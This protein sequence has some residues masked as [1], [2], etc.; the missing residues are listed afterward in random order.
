MLVEIHRQHPVV[1]VLCMFAAVSGWH[2]PDAWAGELPLILNAA[3]VYPAP[4]AAPIDDAVVIVRDG[5]ILAAASRAEMPSVNGH[6]DAQC[7]GG[8]V[9]AGFQNSHV[10]FIE[11]KWNDAGRQPAETL[12]RNLSEMLTRYGFTTVVDTA[13]DVDNTVALRR[14]IESG[15][16]KGPRILTT[17]WPL[18]PPDGIPIYLRDMPPEFLK[19]LPQPPSAEQAIGNVRSNLSR[20]ADAIKLFVATPIADGSVKYMSPEIVE[21]A[22]R[23]THRRGR[24]VGPPDGHFRDSRGAR[25]GRGRSRAHDARQREDGMGR[26]TDSGHAGA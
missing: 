20:G 8:F 10:H 3:R 25:G 7:S 4:D 9:T 1:A 2:C 24:L 14:R 21:A 11:P 6:P 19:Q 12:A 18:F 23:E 5:R 17:G 26:D 22:T 13:S 15:E 16:V